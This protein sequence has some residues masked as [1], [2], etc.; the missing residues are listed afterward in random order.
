[1]KILKNTLASVLVLSTLASAGTF[2]QNGVKEGNNRV[3]ATARLTSPDEGDENIQFIGQYGKF[4]TDDIEIMLDVFTHTQNAET[5][6]MLGAGV[7]YYFAKTPTL[8]PYIGAQ[9]YHS[10]YTATGDWDSNGMRTNIG[11]HKFL[12]ENFA[13]TP[14][15][16]A[17]FIDFEDY[18]ES[19]LNIYLTYFFD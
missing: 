6:Y 4:L 1:M 3:A 19:Y 9:Y 10:D 5:I 14:E 16:G 15:A 8:T 11:A 2:E 18:R 12:T 7:N 13:I 17:L